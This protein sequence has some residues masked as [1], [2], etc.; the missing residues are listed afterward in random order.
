MQKPRAAGKHIGRPGR[1]VAV[2]ERMA[3]FQSEFIED[4]QYWMRTNRKVALGALEAHNKE[5]KS[6][7]DADS[8]A[9]VKR[10]LDAINTSDWDAYAAECKSSIIGDEKP[11]GR[12]TVGVDAAIEGMKAWRV[13]TPDLYCEVEHALVSGDWLITEIVWMGTHT[14]VWDAPGGAIPPTGKPYK[15]SSCALWKIEDGKIV[16]CRHYFD[17]LNLMVQLGLS[18]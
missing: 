14:G 7:S 5:H 12:K 4:L 18:G 10:L 13:S 15:N 17:I 9:V 11:T 1:A 2:C 16:E 8:V 6:M 3:V